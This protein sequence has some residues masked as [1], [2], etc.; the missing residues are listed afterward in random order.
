MSHTR[1]H[2]NHNPHRIFR[3][4]DPDR[5][6]HGNMYSPWK[7]DSGYLIPIPK[8]FKVAFGPDS[9]S[10]VSGDSYW[11]IAEMKYGHG[12]YYRHIK[13]ANGNKEVIHPGDVLHIPRLEIPYLEAF[14]NTK[15]D[16]KK[17]KAILNQITE[18]DW[19]DFLRNLDKQKGLKHSS[20]LQRIEMIRVAGQT[21][22]EMAQTQLTFLEGKATGEGKSVGQYIKDETTSR[23]Y[24]GGVV[25]WWINLKPKDRRRW[26]RRFYKMVADIKKTAPQDIKDIIKFA[27]ARGGGF[28]WAPAETEKNGAFGFTRGDYKLYAGKEWLISATVDQASVYANIA[29]EMVGHNRYGGS[30]SWE[31]MKGSL[32][33]MSNT[34]R[35]LANSGNNSIFSAYGYMETEIFAELYE[36]KYDR[37]DNPTDHPFDFPGDPQ[38][39]FEDVK[40]KLES[41]KENFAPKVA[42]A[43][44]K[45]LWVRVMFDD[46]IS[47]GTQ[48]KLKDRIKTV[49]G[50]SLP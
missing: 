25:S 49:F 40:K 42:E 46:F 22:D 1:L 8:S 21:F 44:V 38:G 18:K 35:T 10:V 7:L 47:S 14:L 15:G 11:K 50:F 23:G 34:E 9:Y 4:H 17:I 36:H 26:T 41:I 6:A 12:K 43:T 13:K 39:R 32:A 37:I 3:R 2:K 29:H 45:G 16:D 31:I 19:Y 48:S 28:V 33:K 27:E 20:L 30:T 5:H 24:G